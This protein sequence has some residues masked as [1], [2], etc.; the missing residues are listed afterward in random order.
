SEDVAY[1]RFE[2][3]NARWLNP[4]AEFMALRAANHEVAWP[5][6]DPKIVASE[7]EKWFWKFLQYEFFRQ[8]KQV[9]EYCATR[10]IAIMGDMPFYVEHDSADV[11][12]SPELFDLDA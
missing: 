12:N 7:H 6:F 1:Q 4:F 3:A 2:K 9:K 11:W 8:W 10:E 5:K